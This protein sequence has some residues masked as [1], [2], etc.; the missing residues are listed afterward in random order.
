MARS[1]PHVAMCYDPIMG[2]A[3]RLWLSEYRKRL[4]RDL[5]GCVLEIGTGTG[6]MLPWYAADA[7]DIELLALEPDEK[8]RERGH[9][10][11]FNVH[12]CA[13]V[14]EQ[15]PFQSG[16]FDAV[17]LSLVLCS[18]KSPIQVLDE[19]A[20]VTKPNGELRVFEHVAA[21]GFQGKFQQVISPMWSRVAGGCNPHRETGQIVRERDEFDLVTEAEISIGIPPIRPFYFGRYRRK[22]NQS[23]ASQLDQ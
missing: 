9:A 1:D 8:M 3:D 4:A 13:G 5:T 18:V 7:H 12:W 21:T 14:G 11:L 23:G 6:S 16:K 20:R 15:L 19:V 17:I 22:S 2:I 10:K